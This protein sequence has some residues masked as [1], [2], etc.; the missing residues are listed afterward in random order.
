MI[1]INM[2]NILQTLLVQKKYEEEMSDEQL[3]KI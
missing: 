1:K 3:L 2:I